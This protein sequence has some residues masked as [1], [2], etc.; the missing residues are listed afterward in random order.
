MQCVM[1][2]SP[3]EFCEG[4]DLMLCF[5]SAKG[6]P[7]TQALKPVLCPISPSPG[8]DALSP[9]RLSG[10]TCHQQD[11]PRDFTSRFS[12]LAWVG[13]PGQQSQ[14]GGRELP[15]MRC[16]FPSV[17][18]QEVA[19][20]KALAPTWE[21]SAHPPECKGKAEL[22]GAWSGD[23]TISLCPSSATDLALVLPELGPACQL[24][25]G[26]KGDGTNYSI[27]GSGH[28]QSLG[29]SRVPTKHKDLG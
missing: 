4:S 29:G 10:G 22:D 13:G 18:T 21:H 28:S 16:P 23:T 11:E 2:L 6:F 3:N 15:V 27:P 7:P 5:G 20:P 9:W 1:L 12:P 25:H 19:L 26:G 17:P 14:A 24:L 8:H